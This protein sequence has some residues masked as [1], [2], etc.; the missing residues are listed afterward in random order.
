MQRRRELMTLGGGLP[1]EYRRVE[2]LE[3][4]GTQY[5]Y[6]DVNIQ[7]GLTVESVQ[8]FTKT[9]CY[10]FGGA[11][12]TDNLRSCFNGNYVGRIQGAYPTNY[13]NVNI[14]LVYGTPY[15]VKTTHS[16]GLITVYLNNV[17]VHEKQ[18]S[19]TVP[20]TGRKSLCFGAIGAS[21][22]PLSN[23][24]Y[25]GKVYSLNV[26]KNNSVLANFIPCIRKSDNKPGMYDTVSKTFYTNAGTGEFIV[27][28]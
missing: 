9:D 27:P 21:G 28:N 23:Y 22:T 13:Y 20:D 4:T 5:F 16:D 24:L 12:T 17:K 15:T 26:S 18:F 8:T 14:G 7:D 19:N 1:G 11:S 6:T 25:K 3:S 2:Y 10:L